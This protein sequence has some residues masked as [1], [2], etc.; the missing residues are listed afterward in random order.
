[1]PY[2]VL[3]DLASGKLDPGIAHESMDLFFDAAG[4]ALPLDSIRVIYYNNS[5]KQSLRSKESAELIQEIIKEKHGCYI[6]LIGNPDMKEVDF[7]LSKILPKEEFEKRGMPAIR[8]AL[9]KAEIEGVVVES[10]AHMYGRIERIFAL[11]KSHEQKRERVLIVSH[12]F[13]MRVIEVYLTVTKRPEE[14]ALEH[15]EATTL[16]TYF[17][18]FRVP[19]DFRTFKRLP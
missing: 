6:P 1:M 11:C 15:L 2:E 17:K 19:Q 10:I 5:G 14:V 18:G 4:S 9:Y 7:D 8:T 12:D 3:A 16:N 13:F